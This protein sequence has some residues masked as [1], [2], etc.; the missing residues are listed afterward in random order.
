M[1]TWSNISISPD[2]PEIRDI[3]K[4][5]EYL[6]NIPADATRIRELITRFEVCHF[7]YKQ[8]IKNINNSITNRKAN[9]IPENIGKNHLRN[10]ENAWKA[11]KTGR[12]ILGQRYI[13]AL[14]K[15]LGE[16]SEIKESDNIIPLFQQ[17]ANWL[18]KKN[19]VKERLVRILQA[20]LAWDW[21]TYEELLKGEETKEQELQ[22]CRIDVCHY[23]F[24]ENI[25]LLLM[26][27]GKMK[28][29]KEFEGCGSCNSE[30]KLFVEKEFILLND[31][32]KSIAQTGQVNKKER[33][34]V[35]LMACFA[36]TLK[37]QTGLK[38]PL[39]GLLG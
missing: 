39:N 37:E 19:P 36:K 14:N 12:S 17:I 29:V 2:D 38:Y 11:D 34:K 18:G 23:A 24:P 7:K 27:I 8:H 20:R 26:G 32:L 10:G 6:E 9:I 33:I 5:E 15:W 30:I 1:N 31:Q 22:V 35:W 25:N 28:P 13:W 3:D 16:D 21:K 4:Y